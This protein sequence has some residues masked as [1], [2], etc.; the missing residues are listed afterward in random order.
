MRDL[1]VMCSVALLTVTGVGACSDGSAVV[2]AGQEDEE[3][4]R[5]RIERLRREIPARLKGYDDHLSRLTERLDAVRG[6][7]PLDQIRYSGRGSVVRRQAREAATESFH[8][9]TAGRHKTAEAI[10]IFRW[11]EIGSGRQ[12]GASYLRATLEAATRCALDT[13]ELA[14]V[15][16]HED[17]PTIFVDGS[18]FGCAD[19]MDRVMLQAS[20]W[21]VGPEGLRRTPGWLG[22][23]K[24]EE[25]RVLVEKVREVNRRV[26]GMAESESP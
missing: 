8:L 12:V 14:L 25:A 16:F 3:Y 11:S 7:F 21:T 13:A 1:F 23:P 20:G 9:A 15:L 19:G 17:D 2:M 18:V 10:Q 26:I 24:G 6:S 5:Q 22:G 4:H